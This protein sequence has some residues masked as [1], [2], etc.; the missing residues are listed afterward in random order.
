MITSGMQ[1]STTHTWS[2]PIIK[3]P[4]S[5]VYS[6]NFPNYFF[7]V[8]KNKHLIIL[9]ILVIVREIL[10]TGINL[11]HLTSRIPENCHWCLGWKKL[12]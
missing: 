2:Q 11:S 9:K 12:R 7:S 5:S 1:I 6:Q 4:I 8:K 3:Q 10:W